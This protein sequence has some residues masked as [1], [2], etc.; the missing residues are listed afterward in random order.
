[1]KKIK[2]L[3]IKTYFKS[4]IFLSYIIPKKKGLLVFIPRHNIKYF[5]GNIKS[6][7]VYAHKNCRSFESI[8]LAPNQNFYL[9]AK[10]ENLNVYYKRLPTF[11]YLLRAEHII[12]NA[13]IG[14]TAGGNFSIIQLWHG[15]GFKNVGLLNENSLNE[16]T[17]IRLKKQYK[18]YQFVVATSE[19]DAI[20]KNDSFSPA[21]AKIT[22]SPRNDI[23]FSEKID[24]ENIKERFNIGLDQ[25]I[26]TYAPTFRDFETSPPFTN[27]FWDELNNELV[28]QNII[29]IIKKHPLDKYLSVPDYFSNIKDL[30]KTVGDVQELLVITDFLISDYSGIIA[31]FAITNR[32]ILLYM[33]DLET[34]KEKCRDFYYNIEEILPK[35]FIYNQVD[36]LNRI[37]DMRWMN[38]ESYIE[39]YSQY[40]NKFHKYLDGNSSKR[41]MDEIKKLNTNKKNK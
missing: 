13:S 14:Y 37:K 10:E 34:Y 30:S 33:Y 19:E 18:N 23:F 32:P 38:E 36:L 21:K 16:K 11:W 7:I 29:F 20:R 17:Q 8:L 9:A 27:N 39:S 3:F 40:K 6:L 2:A 24:N 22:G 25:K 5:S 31:D 28:N 41:V 26:I 35:P 15:T 4:I 1:M 12:T